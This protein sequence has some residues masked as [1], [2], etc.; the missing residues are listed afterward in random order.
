[1]QAEIVQGDEKQHML[2]ASTQH[3]VLRIPQNMA[4]DEVLLLHQSRWC[5]QVAL[6]AKRTRTGCNLNL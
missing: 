6:G 3:I 5:P 2:S 1:M 4:S